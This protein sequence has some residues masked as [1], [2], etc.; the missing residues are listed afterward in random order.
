MCDDNSTQCVTIASFSNDAKIIQVSNQ[1]A[2]ANS[3]FGIH[4]FFTLAPG[5]K[6]RT[7]TFIAPYRYDAIVAGQ[8]VRQWI[9]QLHQNQMLPPALNSPT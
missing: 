4:G 2:S 6:E 3:Y 5:L 9:Y 1:S 7:T 8:S